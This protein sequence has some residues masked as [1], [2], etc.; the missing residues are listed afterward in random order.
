MNPNVLQLRELAL[1]QVSVNSTAVIVPVIV[2]FY[3][4]YVDFQAQLDTSVDHYG[5]QVQDVYSTSFQLLGDG[6][7]DSAEVDVF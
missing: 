5:I 1:G 2:F 7:T 4:D 6:E 3:F